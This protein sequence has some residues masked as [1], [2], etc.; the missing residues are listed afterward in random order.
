VKNIYKLLFGLIL[1][2]AIIFRFWHLDTLPTG[3]NWDEISHGYN[4]YSVMLTGQDQWG[5]K[6]PVF[7]FRAYGD[8]PTTF[9][10]YLTIPF[11]K[12]FG[13]NALSIRLPSAIFGVLFVILMYLFSK[14]LLKNNFLALFCMLL[15][16]VSPWSLFPSR[17]VFQSNFSQVLLLAGIYFFYLGL[18]NPKHLIISSLTFTLSMYSYHNARIITPIII[19]V[20]IYLNF[21]TLKK[22]FSKNK[23]NIY[24]S[25]VIFLIL[26]IPNLVNLFSPGSMARNQWVGIINPNSIN[27][28]NEKRR[29]FTGPEIIN[30]LINN[31][32]IVFT[33][34]LIINYLNLFNPVP[35]FFQGSQNNQFNPPNTGLFYVI[36]LPFF[37]FGLI[38][39][40]FPLEHHRSPAFSLFILFLICL[41]PA[42]LT[43]GDF[44]SIRATSALPFYIIFIAFGISK[45]KLPKI[46]LFGILIIFI[47]FI[48]FI[49]YWRKYQTYNIIYS[50]SWQYGYKQL[51]DYTQKHYTQYSK[52]F[53]TKKY[54]EPHEFILF[55]WPWDPQ[56]YQND[57]NLNWNYHSGWYWVDGFDK[58]T[59]INDWEIKTQNLPANSLLITSPGNY[60]QNGA[61]PQS[62]IYF[63]NN[64]PAFD[65]VS[66]D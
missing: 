14:L 54:G 18:K 15:A 27:L 60:P 5:V 37:Y 3:L 46:K 1:V 31:K 53:I 39:S 33:Q 19:P 66:Y 42:A 56:K 20:L 34:T 44:P 61:K 28:I 8:Y 47:I 6:L 36:L 29:L 26:A 21:S 41:L 59:F 9:N 13:L 12:L 57:P 40:L 64:T 4:A 65:I 58:F 38:K 32:P 2:I 30:R 50:S 11:V 7:N 43:V 10:M 35:L 48:Q 24:L 17:A 63:L 25:L 16:A 23:K 51:V 62:T 22:S 45:I 52:I 49:S 55:Y